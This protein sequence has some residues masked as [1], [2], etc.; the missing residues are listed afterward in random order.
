M[1]HALRSMSVDKTGRPLAAQ[2][3]CFVRKLL[4]LSS[5]RIGS[6]VDE[7]TM[8]KPFPPRDRFEC[9]LCRGS[10]FGSTLLDPAKPATSPMH[11][12]CHGADGGDGQAGCTFDWPDED[13]WKYFLVEGKRLSK[14]D[15][16]AHMNMI[17]STPIE[18]FPYNPQDFKEA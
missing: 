8:S 12:Y 14:E 11:R 5:T 2:N 13:D 10:S 4:R 15:F 16:A 18:A 3:I 9:P 17:R 7:K 1:Q 6:R